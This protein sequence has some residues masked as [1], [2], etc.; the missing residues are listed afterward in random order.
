MKL[1][2]SILFSFAWL[3]SFATII[4]VTN[5]GAD[6]DIRP[7]FVTAVTSASNGDTIA[8]PS[9]SF[10]WGATTTTVTKRVSV[11]GNGIGT[12][13]LYRSEALSDGALSSMFFIEFNI[14]YDLPCKMTIY[15]ITFKS[16]I[17]SENNGADGGS[18]ASDGGIKII[19]AV[20]FKIRD[21]RFENF[22]YA[23]IRI[24]HRDN[25][26]R[27]VIYSCDFIHNRKGG[28]GLGLGYGVAV[29]GEDLKWISNPRFGSRNFIFIESNVFDK[30]RHSVASAG[31]GLYVFRWNTVY[32]NYIK[33]IA[34]ASAVDAHEGTPAAALGSKN[35]H[36]TRAV[37]CYSNTIVNTT[38]RNGNTIHSGVT[39]D[40]LSS[41]A[42]HI[43]GGEALIHN[44]VINGY[45]FGVGVTEDG[46]L[47]YPF[48]YQPGYSSGK[49]RGVSHSGTD[50]VNGEGD[51]FYWSN[52]FTVYNVN[53]AAFFNFETAGGAL[54]SGRDYHSVVK[55]GYTSFTYPHP[56]R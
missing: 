54:V 12:T 13:V 48:K 31:C 9:G 1:K 17:P 38:F 23:A 14:N 28:D 50:A 2:L 18:L 33:D 5:P 53:C 44:N 39:E 46:G 52:S 26:A 20:D 37:E 7:N 27:G 3:L 40:S 32:N 21:C 30:H 42:I 45:R 24:D 16:Q 10:T 11:K 51:V 55:P 36:A 19:N 22:G 25:L 15:G 4:N 56:L 8:F 34:F 35:H 49:R 29:F 6:Q 41:V 43:R 47:P